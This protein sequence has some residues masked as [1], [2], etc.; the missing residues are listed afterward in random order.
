MAARYGSET[1]T[2]KVRHVLGTFF[3]RHVVNTVKRLFY[4]YYLR[5]FTAA[6]VQLVLGWAFLLFGLVF[7]AVKWWHS[8]ATGVPAT[9][10]T[11]FL[12][13][14]PIILGNQFLIA[15][16]DHDTRNMPRRPLQDGS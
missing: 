6:S 11:V 7:G 9:T 4:S 10:G 12:A 1:S 5:D 8:V 16:L 14:L 15:F 13:A 3:R 2:L